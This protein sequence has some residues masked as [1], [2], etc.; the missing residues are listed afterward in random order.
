[1]R[2]TTKGKSSGAGNHLEDAV[3][4][5]ARR[6][7]IERALIGTLALGGILTIGMMA[8]KVMALIRKEHIDAILPGDPKQRLRETLSRLKRKGL[9]AFEERGG[10]KYPYLTKKGIERAECL[11]REGLTITKPVR[12]DR[13]WRIV[14]FDISQK[15]RAQRDRVRGI[16]KRL[17]FYRLQNSVWAHPYDCEEIITLLKLDMRIR[18]EVLYVIADAIEYDRPLREQFD[19]P[20]D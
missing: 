14:I 3:R 15:Q 11:N 20:L 1:M 19:L 5:R 16:L 6:G 10:K 8:P 2:A 7:S 4:R 9:V 17:G 12:W 18:R 13:R